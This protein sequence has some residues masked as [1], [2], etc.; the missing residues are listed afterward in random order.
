MGALNNL[1]V[2]LFDEG[3]SGS[4][5]DIFKKILTIEPSNKDALLN[6]FIVFNKLG[7][8]YKIIQYVDQAKSIA[9]KDQEL[10]VLLKD[11]KNRVYHD[12]NR[13]ESSEIIN[14]EAF[15]ILSSGRCGI[16][17]LNEVI[18]T[19]ENVKSFHATNPEI[20]QGA[21]DAFWNRIDKKEFLS[22]YCYPLI[23]QAAKDGVVFGETTPAITAF[24]DVLTE[25]IPKAKFIILVRDPLTFAR[26]AL[27][28]NFYHGHPDDSYR[29]TPPKNTDAYIQW[30]KMSQVEKIC[31]LWNEFY[32]LIEKT[33]ENLNKD[34]FVVLHYEDLFGDIQTISRLFDF[35]NLKGFSSSHVSEV[36]RVKRNANHYGRFPSVHHW[37]PDFKRI[38]EQASTKH[39]VNYGYFKASPAGVGKGSKYMAVNVK[40]T[41]IVTI[42]IPLYSGG[43]MLTEAVESI[44]AQDFEHFELIISDHGSDPLVREIG[45]HYQKLD[46]RVKYLHSGDKINY[47]GIHNLARMI[48]LSTATYFMWG[49]YD[50]RLEKAFISR[51]LRVMEGD[52]SIALV[53]PRSKVFNEKGEFLGLGADSVKADADDPFDR[54]I[55]VIWELQMCNAFYGLFRRHYMRK[56]RSLQKNCYAH[57]NLFLAEIALLGKIVQIDDVLFNRG[58]TRNYNLSLEKHHADVLRSADPLL[59]E[60]GLTLPFCRFTYAHCELVNHSSLPPARKESLTREIIRCF[61]NRWAIQLNYEINRLINL[62]KKGVYYQTWDGRI[63]KHD[64]KR[65][66][67]NLYFFHVTDVLKAIRE[68]LFIFPNTRSFRIFTIRP[69]PV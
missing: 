63:Y 65:Q 3:Q 33:T 10:E 20:G 67:P 1:G 18:N 19:A 43:K 14:A 26:S 45:I 15:F 46:K 57:D 16:K 62:L 56:T 2:I 64:L 23:R 29:F 69:S 21:L 55:H 32:N 36:L 47:I 5:L 60:E 58:L 13:A 28:Q 41:P 44:L 42:G 27:L 4:A 68:A 48:E 52:D 66:T 7:E 38:I 30:K 61:R 22:N 12:E 31:W 6:L 54:F 34:R 53:Y 11:I 49:S 40:K 9:S 24:S 35:L 8:K 17:T 37:S 25:S 50:D 59:L 51:C 39:A